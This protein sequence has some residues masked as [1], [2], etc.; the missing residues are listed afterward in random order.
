MLQA[1][2]LLYQLGLF[3]IL[4]FD[5]LLK[6]IYDFVILD[7][8]C[9]PKVIYESACVKVKAFIFVAIGT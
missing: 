5:R 6:V 3:V 1:R 8:D 4:D 9:L 2:D 7:F